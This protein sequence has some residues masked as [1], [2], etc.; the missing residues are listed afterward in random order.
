MNTPEAQARYEEERIR[1]AVW[2]S[3]L[4]FFDLIESGEDGPEVL[5]TDIGK[6]AALLTLA[7]HCKSALFAV[8]DAVDEA[9]T[10]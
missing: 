8:C 4:A 6:V 10:R 2:A 5:T 1:A 7:A 3:Y 9:S